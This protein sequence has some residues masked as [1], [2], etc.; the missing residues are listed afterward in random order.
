MQ[1][2]IAVRPATAP[3]AK[4]QV[5]RTYDRH[6]VVT[7]GMR[8][9]KPRIIGHRITVADIATWYL[10]QNQ[11]VDEIAQDFNLTHAQIHAALTYYY[12]IGKKLTSVRP[13]I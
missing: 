1:T 4:R 5:V 8:G 11:S 2:Q 12:A 6:I 9:G 7:A 3:K 13:Q 10:R